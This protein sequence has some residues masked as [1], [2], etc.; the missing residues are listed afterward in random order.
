VCGRGSLGPQHPPGLGG[1]VNSRRE[2][3]QLPRQPSGYEVSFYAPQGLSGAP[4]GSTDHG[5]PACYGCVIQQSTL[6]VGG[7]HTP[8]GI[9]VPIDSL[10]TLKSSSY[11]EAGPLAKMLGRGFRA[12]QAQP[13]R[14]PGGCRPVN[15]AD[16]EGG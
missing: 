14:L 13:E 16:L 10:L 6:G 11:A 2:L 5:H 15:N 3:H 8:V 7:E 4:L 1:W 12:P 9:T